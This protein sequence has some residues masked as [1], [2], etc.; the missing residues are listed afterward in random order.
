MPFFRSKCSKNVFSR[1]NVS[2][3]KTILTGRIVAIFTKEFGGPFWP[4]FHSKM[5][6]KYRTQK[7]PKSGLS[8]SH[9]KSSIT[10]YFRKK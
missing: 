4:F 7:V 1:Q 8:R 9:K 2:L 3:V 6:Y 10:V 5:F